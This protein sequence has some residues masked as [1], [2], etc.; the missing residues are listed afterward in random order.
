[1]IVALDLETTGVDTQKDTIIEIALYKFDEVTFEILESFSTLINPQI[2]IPEVVS[3]ITNIFDEDV[4][5]AP[6]FDDVMRKKIKDFIWDAPL[7]W[8]NTPFDRDMLLSHKVD[9][10]QNIILDTFV[11]ANII[12]F[13]QKSLNLWNLCES[14]EIPMGAA[15]RASDDTLATILLFQ[16]IT[17]LFQKLPKSQKEVLGYIFFLSGNASFSWYHHYFWFSKEIISQEKFIK[18]I[19]SPHTQEKSSPLTEVDLSPLTMSTIQELFQGFPDS[20]IRENQLQM[21]K[22]VSEAFF[23]GKHMVIEAPTWVGK[24]FAYLI[25]SIYAARYHKKSVV[26]STNTKALQDQIFYKDLDFLSKHLPLSFSYTKLKWRKNYLSFLLY[27]KALFEQKNHEYQHIM[28]LSK[29]TLWLFVTE[30]WELDEL[31]FYPG[32]YMYIDEIHSD[33][34]LVTHQENPYK[35]HEFYVQARNKAQESNIIVINHSLLLQDVVKTPSLF[36]QDYFLVVDEAHNL[37]DSATDAWMKKFSLK[38]LKDTIDVIQKTLKKQKNIV[39]NL[40]NIFQTLFLQVEFLFDLLRDFAMKKNT[41]GN[42]IFSCYLDNGWYQDNKHVRELSQEVSW[43]GMEISEKLQTLPEETYG[44]IKNALGH[45]LEVLDIIHITGKK[46]SLLSY[47]P[48][49][50]LQ[51]SWNHDLSYTILVPGNELKKLLWDKLDGVVLTSATLQIQDDFRYIS[52]TLF[53]KDFSFLALKS[54]F[55]YSKQ[56]LLF[57]PTDLGSIKYK[58][59]KIIDFLSQFFSTIGGKWLLL[60]T[61]Y[62]A[63]KELYLELNLLLKKKN[64]TL[65]AQWVSGSK[66]KVA[67]YFTHHSEHSIL[68]GTESFWEWIDFPGEILKYL[69]IHKFPFMVPTDPIFLARSQLYKDAFWEYSIPKAIL[70]TKQWFWRLIRRK[71]DTGIVVLLDDRIHSNWGKRL[72]DSFPKDIKMKSSSSKSFLDILQKNLNYYEE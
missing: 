45:F 34:F 43:L 9:I 7:L 21:T 4:K 66:F 11:L 22:S 8:H 61:S 31:N 44:L 59:P 48:V 54:D 64:I 56:A 33:S 58:N 51:K 52:N 26:I 36:G 70:K 39:D 40:D 1:M 15:H 53:L 42:E 16:K 30:F 23:E 62:A 55:D 71:S 37:E 72:L 68:L 65:L 24:T 46:E 60:A 20:E 29:I 49:F 12:L 3:N 41:F 2:S 32:E 69:V 14:L 10:E 57:L 47:I 50:T 38:S 5:D 19:L 17:S 6:I 25:P 13:E 63:I 67:N 18:K 28:F 35:N 27:F